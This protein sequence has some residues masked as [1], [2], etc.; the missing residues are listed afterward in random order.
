[1]NNKQ[2]SPP[3]RQEIQAALYHV[4]EYNLLTG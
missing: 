3:T 1:M 4:E 2:I